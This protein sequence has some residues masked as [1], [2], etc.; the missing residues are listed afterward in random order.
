[1][2]S[3]RYYP[4]STKS[5]YFSASHTANQRT[6][7]QL[8]RLENKDISGIEIATSPAPVT[9]EKAIKNTPPASSS[10]GAS[11]GPSITS[12]TSIGP[13]IA[14]PRP[15]CI[16][17]PPPAPS[18]TEEATDLE[19]NTSKTTTTSGP[20]AKTPQSHSVGKG[21]A[22]ADTTA[23]D[24]EEQNAIVPST[25]S[26]QKKARR[27]S[28][29]KPP[30]SSN[31]KSGLSLDASQRTKSNSS[32]PGATASELDRASHTAEPKTSETSKESSES[33]SRRRKLSKKPKDKRQRRKWWIFGR[34]SGATAAH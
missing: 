30:S 14:P 31:G 24:L 17:A 6:D 13:A 3:D 12:I 28:K 26:P 27:L 32:A 10:N 33:Q 8:Y 20:R 16:V 23:N 19:R 34:R 25:S 29:P 22:P 7:N 1:M 9:G 11:F 4:P 5:A 21:K 15:P 18:P 2:K